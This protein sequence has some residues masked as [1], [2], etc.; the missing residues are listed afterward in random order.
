MLVLVLVLV[1]VLLMLA[2]AVKG[3]SNRA[4]AFLFVDEK[5]DT[6]NGILLFDDNANNKE[7]NTI[8][9]E[10]WTIDRQGSRERRLRFRRM[11]LL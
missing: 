7:D 6:Y 10:E 9:R 11:L 4:Q 5:A 1:L 3:D 8:N 2:L